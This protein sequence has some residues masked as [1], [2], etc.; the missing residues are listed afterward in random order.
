M[1]DEITES[2]SILML[3]WR[4]EKRVLTTIEP[5]RIFGPDMHQA[6]EIQSVDAHHHDAVG[7]KSVAELSFLLPEKRVACNVDRRD[8]G[9][10]LEQVSNECKSNAR[11][12]T[13]DKRDLRQS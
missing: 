2:K 13:R 3:I 8:A 1:M 11:G 6:A 12:A 4:S 10:E 9:A 7:A 5:H